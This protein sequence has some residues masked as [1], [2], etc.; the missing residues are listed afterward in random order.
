MTNTTD[1]SNVAIIV[2]AGLAGCVAAN[3]LA[4]YGYQVKLFEKSSEIGG[5]CATSEISGVQVHK[6]GPHIFHTSDISLWVW[7]Q[8]YC[9]MIPYVNSPIA[10]Y[11]G[12]LYNLPFNMNT[13]VKIFESDK[14]ITPNDA[15]SVISRE[16]S[17]YAQSHPDFDIHNPKNLEE[18]AISMVGTTIYE[19][20][21]KGYTEKQWNTSCNE[22]PPSIISRLPLRYVFDNNYFNDTYQGIPEDGYS[23]LFDNLITSYPTVVDGGSIEL[24]LNSDVTATELL[25]LRKVFPEAVILYSGALDSLCNY[26]YDRLPFRSLKFETTVVDESQGVAV[27]N[28]TDS[29]SKYTRITEHNLFKRSEISEPIIHTYEY[30]NS[31]SDGVPYYPMQADSQYQ[32]YFDYCKER[33]GKNFIPI[34]RAGL[35]KYFNMDTIIESTH[36]ICSEILDSE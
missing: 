34:G 2:G 30:P 28:Y 14:I 20:L 21:V 17:E 7:L 12:E 15:K 25:E 36:K 24:H 23:K 27:M 26:I 3:Y 5:A 11:H 1:S 18:R 8:Q 32:R 9:S 10:N 13:F 33:Y 16:I 4:S 29:E 22:L 19:K 6:Y 31:D 35:W